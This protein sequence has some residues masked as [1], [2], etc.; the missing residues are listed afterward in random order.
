M[1]SAISR[2][3]DEDLAHAGADVN[4]KNSAGTTA[5]T[6]LAAAAEADEVK[7][8]LKAG[9]DVTLKDAT[10]RTALDYLRLANCGRNPVPQ[11]STFTTGGKCDQL[12]ED[13]VREVAVLLK[14]AKRNPGR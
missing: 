2:L 5:L 3:F 4:A 13:D 7:H 14:T 1:A 8:A 6:I 10:G 12:D 9:A 11:Y